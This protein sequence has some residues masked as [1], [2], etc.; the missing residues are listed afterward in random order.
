[1]AFDCE[2]EAALFVLNF[3]PSNNFQVLNLELG[4]ACDSDRVSRCVSVCVS[5]AVI[6]RSCHQTL[7][8]MLS[9]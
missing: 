3:V 8:Q 7:N 5:L 2:R 6:A 4:V 1:M 9:K